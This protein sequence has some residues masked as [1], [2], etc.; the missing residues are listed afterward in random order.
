MTI[1]VHDGSNWQN[2]TS[3]KIH[4]G[5]QWNPAAAGFIHDGTD[6]RPVLSTVAPDL[7]VSGDQRSYA[8]VG[9]TITAYRGSDLSGTYAYQWWWW[10]GSSGYPSSNKQAGPSGTLTG[11]TTQTNL[12][13]SLSFDKRYYQIEI[14]YLGQSYWS[15]TVYI[16]KYSP[17]LTSG[18]PF[19]GD[20]GGTQIY[21]ALASATV[22]GKVSFS[23]TSGTLIVDDQAPDTYS[24]KWYDDGVFISGSETTGSISSGSTLTVSYTIPS[25]MS[26]NL[27]FEIS[28]TNSGGT[29][30][31]QSSAISVT[32][33]CTEGYGPKTYGTPSSWSSCSYSTCTQ[34]RTI[35][36]SRVHTYSD[37][38]TIT[39]YGSD[40]ESQSCTITPHD[41]AMTPAI[42]SDYTWSAWSSCNCS[43]PNQKSRSAA[44]KYVHHNSDCTTSTVYTTIYEY[45]TCSCSPSQSSVCG[46]GT[47]CGSGSGYNPTAN[48]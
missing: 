20:A 31:A 38:S 45:Q 22:Y 24:A 3:T 33:G 15:D 17:V 30:T 29:T 37:C 39:E 34:T 10:G 5:T 27:V 13:T 16:R 19:I 21:S 41:D 28:L 48:P 9:E 18:Y 1:K 36:W 6:W 25:N 8:I 26:G 44:A 23:R 47:Q 42:G 11:S 7:T 46:S 12:S 14:T 35:P 32:Q 40:T 2:V 43:S 4:D